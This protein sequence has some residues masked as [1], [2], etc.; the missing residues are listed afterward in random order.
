MSWLDLDPAVRTQLRDMPLT[1]AERVGGHLAAAGFLLEADPEEAYEHAQA[2]RRLAQRVA[3]VREAAG[4]TAYATGRWSEAVAELR[5][6]RRFTGSAVHLPIVADCERALGHPDRALDVAADPAAAY[7]E[8]A[9]ALE[10]LLVR[11]GARRDL[12]QP[13]AALRLLDVSALHASGRPVWLPRLRYAYADTLLELGRT[14]EAR[15]WFAATVEVD[16]QAS[17]DAAERLL[18]LAG[19]QFT[20]VGESEL[21]GDP[22]ATTAGPAST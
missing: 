7:L 6:F 20:E 1:L 16:P 11:A 12:G 2:A 8:P 9:V 17:T 13:D 5:A 18:E 4:L 21:I 19:T 22:E 14:Q 3:A 10:L 15:R